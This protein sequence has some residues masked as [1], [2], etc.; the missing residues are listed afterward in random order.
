MVFF[1]YTAK[2]GWKNRMNEFFLVLLIDRCFH[3]NFC[4]FAGKKRWKVMKKYMI[5]TLAKHFFN[6]Q[7]TSWLWWFSIGTNRIWEAV[8]GGGDGEERGGHLDT[9]TGLTEVESVFPAHCHRWLA[10]RIPARS[11]IGRSYCPFFF[12]LLLLLSDGPECRS[13]SEAWRRAD[14]G[15]SR[16]SRARRCCTAGC[17]EGAGEEALLW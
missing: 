12:F 15:G 16:Q 5:W 9:L 3:V 13:A 8:L 4:I 14:K 10:R 6:V 7:Q 11:P 17:A 1:L 2:A